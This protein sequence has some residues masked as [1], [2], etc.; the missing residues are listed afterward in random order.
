[1]YGE[2]WDELWAAPSISAG[3]CCSR[4]QVD[5]IAFE[6]GISGEAWHIV[7]NDGEVRYQD[8]TASGLAGQIRI[9][10]LQFR[11]LVTMT[12]LALH[13]SVPAVIMFFFSSTLPA[14]LVS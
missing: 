6:D 2:R 13:A 7:R 9:G 3:S 14:V 8:Q 11:I 12:Q 5:I 4:F 10:V 1:M